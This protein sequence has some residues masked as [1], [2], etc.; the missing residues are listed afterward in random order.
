MDLIIGQFIPLVEGDDMNGGG[1]EGIII[2]AS[3]KLYFKRV[4]EN[5]VYFF[6][7]LL[8]TEIIL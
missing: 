3:W 6:N 4:H 2:L 8:F 5:L 7:L 1:W